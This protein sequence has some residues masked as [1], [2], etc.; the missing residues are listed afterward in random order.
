MSDLREIVDKQR[1][2]VKKDHVWWVGEQVLD[3]CEGH[4]RYA[5][6]VKQDLSGGADLKDIEKK[7]AA[8]ARKNGG[9]TPPNE[10]ERIIMEFF[11]LTAEPKT[12][13][14]VIDLADFF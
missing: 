7:I 12:E 4:P 8:F 6:I 5:E 9:C 13:K 3:I 10:A 2:P 1:D 14:G 11:G